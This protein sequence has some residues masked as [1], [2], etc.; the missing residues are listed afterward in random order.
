MKNITIE[1]PKDGASVQ[2]VL[3]SGALS[4]K[5]VI[6]A[7]DDVEVRLGDPQPKPV[8]QP[9]PAVKTPSRDLDTILKRL[10]KLKPTKRAAAINSI[11]AMF[12][13]TDPI[14]DVEANKFLDGLCKRGSISIDANDKLHINDR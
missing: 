10:T 13:L 6:V 14:S 4:G 3:R 8:V 9:K 1:I 11:K 5:V 7:S 12:Q 2:F